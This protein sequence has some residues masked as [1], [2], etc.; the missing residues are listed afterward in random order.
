[1]SKAIRVQFL[2]DIIQASDL[3][4]DDAKDDAP[5]LMKPFFSQ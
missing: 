3:L 4:C 2:K 1:M 5:A